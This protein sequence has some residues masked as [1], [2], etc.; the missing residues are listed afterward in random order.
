MPGEP[1]ELGIHEVTNQVLP[2]P[3]AGGLLTFD[4]ETFQLQ[5]VLGEG[6]FGKVFQGY[7]LASGRF[8]ALKS[9][10][11]SALSPAERAEQISHLREEATAMAALETIHHPALPGYHDLY[12][13]PN[14]AVFRL[15]YIK[16]QNLE[17]QAIA[18]DQPLPEADLRLIIRSIGGALALLHH[19]PGTVRALLP[20]GHNRLLHRD[21]KPANMIA[22][23]NPEAPY[24]LLDFGNAETIRHYEHSQTGQTRQLR[25]QRYGTPPYADPLYHWSGMMLPQG[26]VYSFA[27]TLLHLAAPSLMKG[28]SD[29]PY[30]SQRPVLAELVDQTGLSP[31]LKALLKRSLSL[32]I[33]Q[34][35]E[36]MQEFLT[37]LPLAKNEYF[38][39]DAAGQAKLSLD[40]EALFSPE[41][42]DVLKN[43]LELVALP[44]TNRYETTKT[45]ASV[46][47]PALKH[48]SVYRYRAELE[49]IIGCLTYLRR[50]ATPNQLAHLR[51]ILLHALV[52]TD[53]LV[54]PN[55]SEYDVGLGDRSLVTGNQADEAVGRSLVAG[56]NLYHPL[57]QH[58]L[59][60]KVREAF[61]F[62]EPDA[63]YLRALTAEP[64]PWYEALWRAGVASGSMDQ[65]KA[66]KQLL[67]LLLQKDVPLAQR[68]NLLPYLDRQSFTGSRQLL[69]SD[70][71]TVLDDT[72]VNYVAAWARGDYVDVYDRTVAVPPN[73]PSARHP[74]NKDVAAAVINRTSE[75][76]AARD[77]ILH[78]H[79]VP[80]N[81]F[82]EMSY[83]ESEKFQ[84]DQV[85]LFV[86]AL[87]KEQKWRT[88]KTMFRQFET[89]FKTQPPFFLMSK[90]GGKLTDLDTLFLDAGVPPSVLKK[91]DFF[92]DGEYLR[93]HLGW[94]AAELSRLSFAEIAQTLIRLSRLPAS[95]DLKRELS[96]HYEGVFR[97]YRWQIAAADPA[98]VQSLE[99]PLE[100]I[101]GGH[102]DNLV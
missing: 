78:D 36:D 83:Q 50:L 74:I 68:I 62:T 7:Q 43:L 63:Y 31:E 71:W 46:T 10:D 80:F 56:D 59:H 85:R 24:K 35:P 89:W 95:P 48:D 69:A 21:V 1:Q 12:L 14:Q 64:K 27:A 26:D 20:A 70:P 79:A 51:F 60:P 33:G 17:E 73:L 92:G 55:R 15:E 13:S 88:G 57:V 99:A 42:R 2:A 28:M 22:T 72:Y 8:E 6:G 93:N 75:H 39:V 44:L 81:G 47:E 9:I 18:S 76:L 84:A 29:E 23:T 52:L 58:F 67:P 3:A 101:F 16:G 87:S 11:L 86:I 45:A 54:L 25:D 34:R 97:R 5:K 98:F 53:D 90:V 4:G 65:E 66:Q 32:D 38:T 30:A 41:Q 40:C 102:W 82:R 37:A 61:G 100:K 94:L 49:R 96:E 19:P 91:M 77:K